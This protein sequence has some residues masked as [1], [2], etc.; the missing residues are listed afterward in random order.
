MYERSSKSNE[1]FELDYEIEIFLEYL[2]SCF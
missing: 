1:V 2:L